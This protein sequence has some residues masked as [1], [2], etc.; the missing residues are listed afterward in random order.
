MD[1][2]AVGA[3]CS[4]GALAGT[5]SAEGSAP[6]GRK[7]VGRPF[8]SVVRSVGWVD[9]ADLADAGL[10]LAAS[11]SGGMLSGGGRKDLS[12]VSASGAPVVAAAP[13]PL[14]AP[15]GAAAAPVRPMRV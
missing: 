10:T 11:G 14:S 5:A 4:A 8:A 2:I 6:G 12:D 15:V 9:R 1:I 3:V 7:V 13:V